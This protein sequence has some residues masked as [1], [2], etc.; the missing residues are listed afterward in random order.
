MQ[1]RS[2]MAAST[3]TAALATALAL[4]VS[5]EEKTTT[6]K[7]ELQLVIAG[8]EYNGKGCDVEIKPVHS[9]CRFQPITRHIDPKGTGT[10]LLND[11]RTASADKECAFAITMVEPGKPT[12][13]VYKGLR[14]RSSDAA[15]VVKLQCFLN[16]PTKTAIAS[17]DQDKKRR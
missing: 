13:T 15:S 2:W 1:G 6:H 10:V 9:G 8:L 14:L 12:Q 4:P 16:S 7:V 11:V 5:A 17:E 3:L